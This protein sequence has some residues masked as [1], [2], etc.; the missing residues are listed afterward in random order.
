MVLVMSKDKIW[1]IITAVLSTSV[2]ILVFIWGD[3]NIVHSLII[4][5]LIMA[6]G[7]A[8]SNMTNAVWTK[9]ITED[10]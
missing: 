8:A 9:D 1:L 3:K 7:G 2:S 6:Y 10:R 5:G 4:C